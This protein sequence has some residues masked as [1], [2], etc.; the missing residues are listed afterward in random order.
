[1]QPYFF[2]SPFIFSKKL[3]EF[4]NVPHIQS[5]I[6]REKIIICACKHHLKSFLAHLNLLK[7]APE[8]TWFPF[9]TNN[10]IFWKSD[11]WVSTLAQI[12]T[13]LNPLIVP[14]HVT[15]LYDAS[16]G[17]SNFICL[18]DHTIVHLLRS[19]FTLTHLL[20]HRLPECQLIPDLL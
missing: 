17:I 1:M 18:F 20:N 10:L 4:H 11:G 15:P 8:M 9:C 6:C 3:I 13:L 16:V 2:G 5:E 19:K 7:V 12:I 14:G